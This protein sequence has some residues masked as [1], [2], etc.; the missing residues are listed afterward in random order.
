MI[1]D[2]QRTV[3]GK[4]VGSCGMASTLSI[5]DTIA[6]TFENN[7]TRSSCFLHSQVMMA[8][9]KNHSKVFLSRRVKIFTLCG[10]LED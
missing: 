8:Q 4:Y 3:C 9:V 10:V 6:K 2:I 1:Y 5:A 7:F